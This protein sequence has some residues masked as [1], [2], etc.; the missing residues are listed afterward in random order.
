MALKHLNLSIGLEAIAFQSGSFHKE[1]T[2]AI[3]PYIGVPTSA[4]E[5][6]KLSDK[7]EKLI[8][9]YTN[10]D[11]KVSIEA[12]YHPCIFLQQHD[13]NSIFAN[14]WGAVQYSPAELK[15]LMQDKKKLG[16][17]DLQN[18]RV[19]GVFAKSFATIYT[20]PNYFSSGSFTAGELSAIFLHE[21]GHYFGM[22]EMLDRT[23]GTNQ[24]LASVDRL[25]KNN[26]DVKQREVII[27]YAGEALGLE[28]R[29]IAKATAAT[30]DSVSTTILAVESYQGLIRTDQRTGY[31]DLNTPE[32]T[33][34]EFAA[35]HGASRDLITALDKLTGEFAPFGSTVQK[36]GRVVYIVIEILKI[37]LLGLSI[38]VL[39]TGNLIPLLGAFMLMIADTSEAG[40]PTYDS[41][42]NRLGRIRRQ[43]VEYAKVPSL[44]RVAAQKLLEDIVIIDKL[45][46]SYAPRRDFL[47]YVTDL[48]SPRGNSK[49]RDYQ[50]KLE[51]LALNDLFAKALE[52]KLA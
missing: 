3:E 49:N 47:T 41:V 5:Y 31:Y 48:L 32:Y 37:V 7:I 52:L 51:T 45:L 19:T 13:V 6:I 27:K 16:T 42:L 40:E 28:D 18:S 21:V 39:A 11:I 35:R 8:T 2:L 23:A 24:V 20:G 26:T 25:L 34:D 29:A 9:K 50:V 33:S 30:N 17:V 14:Y 43:L 12:G 15:S 46:E 44:P 10:A 1:L 38:A 36:R 4:G 22:C